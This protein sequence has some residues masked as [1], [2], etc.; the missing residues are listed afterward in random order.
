MEWGDEGGSGA[1][2][3]KWGRRSRER[4]VEK[5]IPD[6]EQF[7]FNDSIVFSRLQSPHS[8]ILFFIFQFVSPASKER[9]V[10]SRFSTN[11]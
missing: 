5:N 1:E 6:R 2:C 11:E 9:L 3:V 8:F 10:L 7:L 4:G